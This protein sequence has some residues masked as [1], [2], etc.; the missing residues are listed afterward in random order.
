MS[1]E[2]PCLPAA[3]QGRAASDEKGCRPERTKSDEIWARFI[4]GPWRAEG[5][6]PRH[7]GLA[8]PGASREESGPADRKLAITHS[9]AE[10]PTAP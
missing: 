2:K 5:N 3:E 8:S 6:H 7:L 10:V 9:P 1:P 4:L